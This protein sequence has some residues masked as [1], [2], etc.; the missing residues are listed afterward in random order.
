MRIAYLYD[1]PLDDAKHMKVERKVI[2]YPTTKRAELR[3]LIEGG[4]VRSGDVVVVSKK[5]KL[6]H[7]RASTRVASLLVGAGATVE[8]VDIPT[9]KKRPVGKW[10][11]VK[12]K[13]RDLICALW[14]SPVD[15]GHV[16]NRA[17][18]ILKREVDRNA[19]NYLC[20]SRGGPKPNT[21][22]A[23]HASE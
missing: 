6:G 18:E 2:D 1:Q 13:D 7:G 19:I 4:G 20:G 10:K 16:F 9:S 23:D 15:P 12:P 8:V 21:K 5:S 17:F 11:K 3:G 22:E 14:H